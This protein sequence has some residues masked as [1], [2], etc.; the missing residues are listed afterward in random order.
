MM[1]IASDVNGETYVAEVQ[2]AHALTPL[3]KKGDV[4]REEKVT[5]V[6]KAK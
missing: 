3:N 2:Y 5:E 4:T 1:Q 6:R